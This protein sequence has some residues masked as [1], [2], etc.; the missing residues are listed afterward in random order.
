MSHA[1]WVRSAFWL[2][3]PLP[4]TEQQFIR[5]MNEEL[6]PGLRALPGVRSA[7]ILWPQQREDHPPNIACQILVEFDSRSE[8]DRMLASPERPALRARVMTAA[9]LFDGSLSH[10][11]YEIR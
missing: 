6:L 4:G 8:L 9:A 2:G 3:T 11:N 7:Q 1:K 5:A 10:I